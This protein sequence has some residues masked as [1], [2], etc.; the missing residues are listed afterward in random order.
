MKDS[1]GFTLIELLLVIALLGIVGATASPLFIHHELFQERFFIDELSN[2]LRFAHKVATATG[3]EVQVRYKQE[4][5]LSL[6]M[7]QDCTGTEFSQMVASPFL[8]AEN[9][10]YTITVPRSLSLKANLPI[11]IESD[12]KVF[13]QAHHWQKELKLQVKNNQIVIDGFSGF[14]YE[15]TI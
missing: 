12:G 9:Q 6:Y 4:N 8:M 3:C 14:V 10:G 11:Y 5:E 15:K 7:R 1:H 2:M 13:D